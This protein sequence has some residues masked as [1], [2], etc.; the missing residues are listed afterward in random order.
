MLKVQKPDEEWIL[1][2]ARQMA[3]LQSLV[4]ALK[5]KPTQYGKIRCGQCFKYCGG[6]CIQVII[7]SCNGNGRGNLGTTIGR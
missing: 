4:F 5:I 1:A 3:S 2:P 7:C 6:S